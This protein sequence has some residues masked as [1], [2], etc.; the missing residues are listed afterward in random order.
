MVGEFAFVIHLRQT[1]HQALACGY[2]GKHLGEEVLHHLERSDRLAELQ[3]LLCVFQCRLER[4]HLDTGRGPADHVTRHPEHP[5]GIAERVAALQA[6]GFRYP[7]I[8]QRD[9]AVLNDLERDLVLNLLDA[10]SGRGLVL[11]DE[12]LHLIVG[13]VARPDDRNV[14]PRRVADPTL[15]AIEHPRVAL[16]LRGGGQPSAASRTDEW[17]GKAEAADLFPTRHRWQPFALLLLRSIEIDRA[18]CQTAVHAKERAKRC[19]NTRE[20]HRAEPEQFLAPA[21]PA[22]AFE[23]NAAGAQL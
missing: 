1:D 18:H 2:V 10:E 20:L 12:A 23:P 7:D 19:V 21:G 11:D 22:I 5:R 9:D 8:L 14:A 17:F 6:I 4:A 15:L 13:E 3:P 16:A